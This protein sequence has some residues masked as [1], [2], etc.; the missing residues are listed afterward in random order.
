MREEVAVAVRMWRVL[1]VSMW[2]AVAVW[3]LVWLGLCRGEGREE[4][5]REVVRDMQ[6]HFLNCT[7]QF[8]LEYNNQ[9]GKA[10]WLVSNLE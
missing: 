7:Q 3:L 2:R 8:K 5:G 9:V 1:V 6:R 4:C 10:G